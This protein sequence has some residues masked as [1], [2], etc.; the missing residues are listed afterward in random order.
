VHA[1][2]CRA[3]T[4]VA[5]SSSS[6]KQTQTEALENAMPSSDTASST[7]VHPFD[8]STLG[9]ITDSVKWGGLAPESGV[10]LGSTLG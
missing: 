1:A 6:W 9:A 5:S 3:T 4:A 10:V 7:G 2:A 8:G